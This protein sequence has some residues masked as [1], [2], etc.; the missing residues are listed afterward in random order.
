MRGERDNLKETSHGTQN[1]VWG[2]IPQPLDHNLSRNLELVAYL[3]EPS[4]RPYAS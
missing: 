4:R 3:T 1:P 2:L